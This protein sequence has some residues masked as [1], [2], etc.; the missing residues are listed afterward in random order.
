MPDISRQEARPGADGSCGDGQVEAVDVVMA[1][2]PSRP[3]APACSA[4]PAS[5]GHQI[6]VDNNERAGPSPQAR[7]G[8]RRRDPER[9]WST[10]GAPSRSRSFQ[11]PNARRMAAMSSP[12]ER[13]S[14]YTVST[15]PGSGRRWICPCAPPSASKAV[16]LAGERDL[17]SPHDVKQHHVPPEGAASIGARPASTCL[18]RRHGPISG[19]GA[20]PVPAET[21]LAVAKGRPVAPQRR[22]PGEQF[23]SLQHFIIGRRGPQSSAMRVMEVRP[24]GGWSR[25]Q[26]PRG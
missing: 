11:E 22:R 12:I 20:A 5:T 25:Y 15:L 16:V 18:P 21:K 1:A 3:R 4:T 24:A 10:Q 23:P 9:S 17:S 26:P 19:T 7:P 13:C 8:P 6:S 2:K 14:P